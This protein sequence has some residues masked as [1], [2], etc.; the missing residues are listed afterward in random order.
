MG[1]AGT[2]ELQFYKDNLLQSTLL[3]KGASICV[4]WEY[5]TLLGADVA[6]AAS[7]AIGCQCILPA[8]PTFL[9]ALAITC[10]YVTCAESFMFCQP[11]ELVRV[12]ISVHA[13]MSGPLCMHAC[14]FVCGVRGADFCT[15]TYI[16]TTGSHVGTMVA[17]A[18][19]TGQV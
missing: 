17:G 15:L 13:S 12:C 6:I 10:V 5:G 7:G 16:E 9:V 18:E 11:F 4:Y 8:C 2:S 14:K 3:P 19:E 1:G